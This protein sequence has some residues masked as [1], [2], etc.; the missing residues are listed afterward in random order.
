MHPKFWSL[1][2]VT[3]LAVFSVTVLLFSLDRT[4]TVAFL[5]VGQ[6]DAMY[7]RAPNG[8]QLLFDA[9]PPSG[10]VLRELGRVMPFWD[11]SI[12]VVVMSHPDL[13]H[14]GG[15]PDVLKRYDVDVLL[16]S[17]KFSGNG[18]YDAVG[19]SIES[20]GVERMIV[21]AGM[22][23][24]LG[25]GAYADILYPDGDTSS[26]D[27]NDASIVLRFAYG[28][29]SVL[30]SGDLS[31]EYESRLALYYG[32]FLRSNVLKLGHHGS[33]TSSDQLWISAV[34]PEIAIISAG[35]DNPYGHPHRETLDVLGKMDIPYLETSKEGS[36]VFETDGVRLSRKK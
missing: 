21:S 23:I 18:A 3:L 7:I 26:L 34:M 6:G 13:D 20:Y 16:E 4:V 19:E 14:T 11:R 25:S 35:E 33:R 29:T 12:D 8:N 1:V 30:A 36:I 24:D 27:T 5:D 31:S 10:A 2:S 17:G 28:E 15:I 32:E 9:G 22:R